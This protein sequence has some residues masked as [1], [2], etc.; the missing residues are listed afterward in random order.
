MGN[1]QKNDINETIN[2]NNESIIEFNSSSFPIYPLCPECWK[3]IPFIKLFIESKIPKIKIN[4]ICL[5]EHSNYIILNLNEY[6]NKVKNRNINLFNCI[7]HVNING[8]FFCLNCENWFCEECYS[9][10]FSNDNIECINKMNEENCLL[11]FCSEHINEKNKFYCIKCNHLFCKFC[12]LSHNI[13]KEIEHKGV[14]IS[15]YLT[16]EKIK[17]KYNKYKIFIKEI[18]PYK[19]E[20]KNKIMNK[21][22][23]ADKIG[24]DE[25]LQT[26]KKNIEE[27]FIENKNINELI[28]SFID[29]LFQSNKYFKDKFI[30]NKKYI[31]NIINSIQFNITKLK[32]DNLIFEEELSKILDYFNTNFINIKLNG[33]LK[34]NKNYIIIKEEHSTIEQLCILN[35]NKFASADNDYIIK[36]WDIETTKNIFTFN[37][38]TNKITSLLPLS[39]NRLASASNDNTIIIWDYKLGSL[40]KSII[41]QANP[42]MIYNI[43]GKNYQIG[44]FPFRNS[45]NIYDYSEDNKMIFEKNLENI[46]PWIESIYHFPKDDRIILSYIGFFAIFS[47][48]IEEIKKITI[49]NEIPKIFLQISNGDL[50]VGL[51]GGKIFIYD[52]NLIFKAKLFGHSNNIIGLIQFNENI[53]LSYSLDYSIKLWS[54]KDKEVIETFINIEN[55]IN[56]VI[57]IGNKQFLASFDIKEFNIEKWEIDIFHEKCYIK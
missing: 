50:I 1:K 9:N 15:N 7:N 42:F 23:I 3:K 45:I 57:N 40:I 47:S 37:Q 28:I 26:F 27:S 38:H 21:I 36:I 16:K 53:L 22:K 34:R 10:H 11:L 48:E 19:L 29:I 13:K 17:S 6:I 32:I 52:K 55:K 41:T 44:C 5:P 49:Y 46:I 14:N 18:I 43:Y 31:I 56:S 51:L 54:L 30:L 20:M 35:D 39:N 12:F 25:E 8:I 4:C 24:N 33:N 2:N